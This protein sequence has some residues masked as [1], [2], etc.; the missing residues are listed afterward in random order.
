V[1]SLARAL[2]YDNPAIVHKFLESWNLPVDEALDLFTETKRWLWLA[3]TLRRAGSRQPGAPPSS[4]A[5]D[6]PLVLLD[7]M[8]HTFILFT[9]EYTEYCRA[10]FGSYVHHAPTTREELERR[11]LELARTPA[12]ARRTEARRMR[13]QYGRVYQYLGEA[14]LVKWYGDY[15]ERYTPGFLRSIQLRVG[16]RGPATA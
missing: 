13:L 1:C 5:I 10:R 4:L 8:W 6:G 2:D 14:T 7:E 3:A 16:D 12:A 15:A 11:A 9:R